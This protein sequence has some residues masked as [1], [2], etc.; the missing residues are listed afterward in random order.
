MSTTDE[1]L[2]A[3]QEKLATHR[4]ALTAEVSPEDFCECADC[5][6]ARVERKLDILMAIMAETLVSIDSLTKSVGP[7]MGKIEKSPIMK[8]LGGK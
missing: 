3:L 5:G 8:M 7:I 2:L 6:T 1:N 4:E